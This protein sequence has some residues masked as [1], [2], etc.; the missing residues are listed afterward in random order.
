[1]TEVDILGFNPQDLFNHEDT[2]HASG[3]QNIYKPRPADSKSEDGIYRS[4]I[5][6]IYNPYDVKNSILEQ[7]AYAM[8]DKDGWFQ[9][10]SKLTNNDTSCPI[11]TAWKKCRYAP[12]G[13]ILN[14]QHKKG[15][16]EKR[17]SRYVL[18]QVMDD[19]NNPDLNG[20]Y[21]FWKLPKSIYDVINAKMNPAKESGRA[22]IPVMDF[23]FG[24]EI[25]LEVKPGPDDPKQPE[26]KLREISYMGEI[27]DDIVSCTNPDGTSL[28]TP[29]E[30]KVLDEY[31]NEMKEVWKSRDPE[32]RATRTVAIN[33][34]ENTK[35][36]G[37]I[38]RNV[39]EKIKGFAPN[40]IEELGYKEWSEDV[41]K[42]VQNWIDIV[43]K[44]E[45][46]KTYGLDTSVVP[47]NDPFGLESQNESNPDAELS[48]PQTQTSSTIM[49]DAP[50]SDLPF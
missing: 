38:Y 36:L 3:S 30:Q 1:M 12:E 47:N 43:L 39:L 13:T 29:E 17:F 9:V 46:P 15:I 40:L 41:A 32:F 26:R 14:E 37:N 16:F 22:P 20:Q 19:K 8:Q 44:G 27:S 35:E 34:L 49:A 24:R 28:L 18:I 6:I 25:Y 2:P 31:V 23:L 7:Q 45:D 21:L 11:F 10:V 48:A 4:T 5:K 33:S 50:E 42:R